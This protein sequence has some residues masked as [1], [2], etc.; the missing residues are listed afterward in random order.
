MA[1]LPARRPRVLLL[2]LPMLRLKRPRHAMATTLPLL[3]D[4]DDDDADDDGDSCW[5]CSLARWSAYLRIGQR[6]VNTATFLL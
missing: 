6:P 5:F 1:L 4:D 3:I 2:L